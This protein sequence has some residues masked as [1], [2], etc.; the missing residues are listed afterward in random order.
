MHLLITLHERFLGV[1]GGIA[2]GHVGIL[3]VTRT[4]LDREGV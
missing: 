4:G 1:R 3:A 2:V